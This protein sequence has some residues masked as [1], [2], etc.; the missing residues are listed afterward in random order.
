[1]DH[2]RELVARLRG[3]GA[4]VAY[5]EVPGADHVWRGAASVPDSVTASLRFVATALDP[6][7]RN[8]TSAAPVG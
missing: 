3:A 5:L 7:V 8:S 1:V 4:V 2:S 6:D